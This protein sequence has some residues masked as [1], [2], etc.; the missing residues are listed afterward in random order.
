MKTILLKSFLILALIIAF[1]SHIHASEITGNLSSS[2]TQGVESSS[3]S[4][5]NGTID[6]GTIIA[7][8][9]IGSSTSTGAVSGGGGGSGFPV[10]NSNSTG[11]VL[12]TSTVEPSGSSEVT[13]SSFTSDFTSGGTSLK[14]KSGD[15]LALGIQDQNTDGFVLGAETAEARPQVQSTTDVG[16]SGGA[17]MNYWLWIL[18]LILLIIA[19]II[20]SYRRKENKYKAR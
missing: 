7:G 11:T 2:S 5:V 3:G 18:L 8:N 14:P 19:I 13:N 6:N 9:V 4:Q 10:N 20:Y 16:E 15:S 17:G 12:G 1:S